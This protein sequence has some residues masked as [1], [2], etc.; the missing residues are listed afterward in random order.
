MLALPPSDA[1]RVAAEGPKRD[2]PTWIMPR[3]VAGRPAKDPTEHQDAGILRAFDRVH[4]G[5]DAHHHMGWG[6]T[7]FRNGNG[8][9]WELEAS[10]D[11]R[12]GVLVP[13]VPV[14][15]IPSLGGL[16]HSSDDPP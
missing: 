16:T 7:A 12:R 13:E 11:R 2:D 8:A 4:P 5:V 1:Q 14:W 6:M 15:C 10:R 9:P 3:R